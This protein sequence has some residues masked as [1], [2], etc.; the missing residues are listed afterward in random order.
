MPTVAYWG[1]EETEP[2]ALIEVLGS[3]LESFQVDNAD[4]FGAFAHADEVLTNVRPFLERTSVASE[5]A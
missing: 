5:L 1:S 4:H 3:S 2:A